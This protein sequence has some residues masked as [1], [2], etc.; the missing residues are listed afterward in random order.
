[1]LREVGSS[2]DQ[3]EYAVELIEATMLQ[4]MAIDQ[5]VQ[6]LRKSHPAS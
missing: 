5:L 6:F 4:Q 1:M 2:S 3:P